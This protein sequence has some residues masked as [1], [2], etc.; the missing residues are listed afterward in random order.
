MNN[1]LTETTK[2]V[3]VHLVAAMGLPPGTELP[4]DDSN[5]TSFIKINYPAVFEELLGAYASAVG[6][7]FYVG[8][9]CSILCALG[10]L[11][12]QHIPLQDG[13]DATAIHVEGAPPPT[14]KASTPEDEEIGAARTSAAAAIHM[15]LAPGGGVAPVLH[16]D[17]HADAKPTVA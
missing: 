13:M 3:L 14:L 10:T 16:A 8:L 2:P 1:R 6:S 9:A 12:M 5:D 15:D 7:V 11:A 17:G 4:K